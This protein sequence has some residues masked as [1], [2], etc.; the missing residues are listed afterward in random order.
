[1]GE[2]LLPAAEHAIL[3]ASLGD[4]PPVIAHLSLWPAH[5]LVDRASVTGLL[6]FGSAV[7]T[8]PL[9]DIAQ[10]TTRFPGWTTEH[11]EHVLSRYSE[12]RSLSP[13]ERRA[14]PAIAALDAVIE[15]ARLLRLG[16]GEE[17]PAASRQA[18][19]A[20]EGAQNLL[21]TI[22]AIASTAIRAVLPTPS[23]KPRPAGTW[24]RSRHRRQANP[25]KKRTPDH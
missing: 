10:I 21:D 3:E 19:A 7:M 22:E 20:R 23:K 25:P 9:L 24:N 17:L 12:H 14:L 15:A 2:Q 4:K 18:V 13:D 5:V 16:Y 6:D 11:A 8:T 1:L